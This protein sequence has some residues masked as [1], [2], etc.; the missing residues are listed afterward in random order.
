LLNRLLGS[1]ELNESTDSSKLHKLSQNNRS[2][3]LLVA[4][5]VI[6][7]VFAIAI[8]SILQGKPE[9]FSQIVSVGP[10]WPTDTWQCTSNSDFMLHGVLR[11]FE[12]AQFAI[13]VSNIGTQSLYT[14][15]Y[16]GQ[17]ES[18]SLGAE[19]DQTITIARTGTVSGFLTLQTTTG[20]TA[21]CIAV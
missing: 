3:V 10:V 6:I 5:A 18:F 12:N 2:Q 14:F 7:I 17:T 4:G 16:Y 21:N 8:S 20:A 9:S 13:G 15:S 1:D 11:G 19:A